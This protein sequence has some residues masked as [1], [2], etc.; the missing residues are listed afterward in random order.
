MSYPLGLVNAVSRLPQDVIRA[1]DLQLKYLTSN[2]IPF[3]A[4]SG[5]HGYSITLRLIQDGVMINMEKFNSS[6]INDDLTATIGSGVS[7]N[8]MVQALSSAER[9]LSWCTLN[10]DAWINEADFQ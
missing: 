6:I 2:N 1:N 7:F 3:L 5:G 10:C 9:E 8:D 4:R